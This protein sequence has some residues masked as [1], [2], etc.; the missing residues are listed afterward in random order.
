MNP[1]L[2]RAR[3]NRQARRAGA[4]RSYVLAVLPGGTKVLSNGMRIRPR[5]RPV[6]QL[7]LRGARL[8]L[9]RGA[10]LDRLERKQ[11][12]RQDFAEQRVNRNNNYGM[13]RLTRD[14]LAALQPNRA[15]DGP[16]ERQSAKADYREQLNITRD[17]RRRVLPLPK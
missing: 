1:V 13:R 14:R 2:A 5:P 3:A 17:N 7:L 10:I 8:D 6:S 16:R 11:T 15:M 4:S 12:F 9:R